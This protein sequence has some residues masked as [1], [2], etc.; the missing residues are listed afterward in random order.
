MFIFFEGASLKIAKNLIKI[1]GMKECLLLFKEK[2]IVN[3]EKE[4][5]LKQLLG[6]NTCNLM[7]TMKVYF[8]DKSLDEDDRLD[9]IDDYVV[10]NLRLQ[11]WITIQDGAERMEKCQEILGIAEMLQLY[12]KDE[13]EKEAQGPGPRYYCVK[14]VLRHLG[15]EQNKELHD[16]LF[17]FVYVQHKQFIYYFRSLMDPVEG[18]EPEEPVKADSPLEPVSTPEPVLVQEETLSPQPDPTG[19]LFPAH[20]LPPLDDL[21]K[22]AETVAPKKLSPFMA[23]I[24]LEQIRS[25]MEPPPLHEPAKI[26]SEAVKPELVPERNLLLDTEPSPMLE[27]N[28]P[29][30]MEPPSGEEL[31]AEKIAEPEVSAEPFSIKDSLAPMESLKPFEIEKTAEPE[32]IGELPISLEPIEEVKPQQIMSPL[33]EELPKIEKKAEPEPIVIESALTVEPV[34]K[35][36]PTLPELEKTVEMKPM[37]KPSGPVEPIS[38]LKPSPAKETPSTESAGIAKTMDPKKLSRLIELLLYIEPTEEGDPLPPSGPIDPSS[39]SP[40]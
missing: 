36:K 20:E 15:N 8:A 29:P 37:D 34:E 25:V 30:V 21:G 11:D 13:K 28:E 31:S 12:W 38:T 26:H 19:N 1:T 17:E 33:R 32:R 2:N 5:L 23:P 14:D 24:Q 39:S 18:G 4:D 9:I 7:Q 3:V 40:N 35:M 22:A 27:E 16:A 10:E 6:L